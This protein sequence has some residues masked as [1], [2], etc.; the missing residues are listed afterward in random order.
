MPLQVTAERFGKHRFST[1]NRAG[2]DR[3]CRS[4]WGS[5]DVEFHGQFTLQMFP[6]DQFVRDIIEIE[7][8]R[9]GDDQARSDSVK[10]ARHSMEGSCQPF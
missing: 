5:H 8:L 2:D 7:G 9:V 6:A 10:V 4:A 3:P 1:A